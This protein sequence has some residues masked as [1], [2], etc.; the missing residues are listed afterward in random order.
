MATKKDKRTK[1]DWVPYSLENQLAV[2]GFFGSKTTAEKH[3]EAS[4]EEESPQTEPVAKMDTRRTVLYHWTLSTMLNVYSG[5][6]ESNILDQVIDNTRMDYRYRKALQA[7]IPVLHERKTHPGGAT[8]YDVGKLVADVPNMESLVRWARSKGLG[9]TLASNSESVALLLGTSELTLEPAW[10]QLSTLEPDETTWTHWFQVNTG[11]F[12]WWQIDRKNL[13]VPGCLT[14]QETYQLARIYSALSPREKTDRQALRIY[15][16]AG[17]MR[18]F[19]FS[20]IS[21]PVLLMLI[22]NA[23]PFSGESWLTVSVGPS[24]ET[25]FLV[26]GVEDVSKKI[27][28]NI[29][30]NEDNTWPQHLFFAVDVDEWEENL[31]GKGA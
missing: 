2:F 6:R 30:W 7:P 29:W 18:D 1:F 25:G 15:N 5:E 3:L 23:I 16:N 28:K 31:F 26:E 20:K 10:F 27:A 13:W 9:L 24:T 11:E 4:Q 21:H 12:T 17:R 14:R 22:V 19:D 8:L